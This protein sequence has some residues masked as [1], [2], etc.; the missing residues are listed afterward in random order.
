MLIKLVVVAIVACAATGAIDRRAVV[1]RHRVVL[2]GIG[3]GDTPVPSALQSP[4]TLTIGNGV[5]GFNAD[6]TG[7]QSLNTTYVTFPLPTLSDW[8]WHSS[9]PDD[10]DV[11]ADYEY[12]WF[13]I[14][15][16]RSVPYPEPMRPN[17]IWLRENPHRLDLIQVGLR[18]QSATFTPLV[19][20]DIDASS[21]KQ[22]L[23]PWSGELV[24]NFS[25]SVLATTHTAPVD[26]SF[27]QYAAVRTRSVMHM[28]LDI[29]SWRVESTLL[30]AAQPQPQPELDADAGGDDSG[31]GGDAAP[32][33]PLVVRVAFPYGR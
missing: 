17:D 5:V 26:P 28:D 24:S 2:H 12:K 27:A 30:A 20:R 1:Q 15:T 22:V 9:P 21:S 6:C 31:A 11:F 16:G 33:D 19:P 7:L 3:Q 18:R 29:L 23:D 13:N 25:V 8:G 10:P 32:A 4:L 14:S